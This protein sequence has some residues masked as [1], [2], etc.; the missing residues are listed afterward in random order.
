MIKKI[1]VFIATI[2]LMASFSIS[3]GAISWYSKST[4][5]CTYHYVPV[6]K[7]SATATPGCPGGNFDYKSLYTKTT[8][9]AKSSDSSETKTIY[10]Y[11]PMYVLEGWSDYTSA[12]AQ[13]RSIQSASATYTI[14]DKSSKATAT[15]SWRR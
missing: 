15:A 3:A 13:I 5:N 14:G 12:T 10:C 4:L 8:V 11:E 7:D 2:C 1:T 9:T 6:L